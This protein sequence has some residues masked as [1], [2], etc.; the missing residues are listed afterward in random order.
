VEHARD[1]AQQPMALF[2]LAACVRGL[3]M[4]VTPTSLVI[5][6]GTAIVNNTDVLAALNTLGQEKL[7]AADV[8]TL[9]LGLGAVVQYTYDCDDACR[10]VTADYQF[11]APG[12]SGTVNDWCYTDTAQHGCP[13]GQGCD[14]D[15]QCYPPNYVMPMFFSSVTW[16]GN[17]ETAVPTATEWCETAGS[18]GNL[19]STLGSVAW[20]PF[21]INIGALGRSVGQVLDAYL[22]SIHGVS[23]A[24]HGSTANIQMQNVYGEQLGLWSDFAGST[25]IHLYDEHG[26]ACTSACKAYTGIFN[27]NPPFATGGLDCNGWTDATA[28]QSSWM[29]SA[30]DLATYPNGWPGGIGAGG[31]STC[32]NQWRIICVGT[33]PPPPP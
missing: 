8:Y 21:A 18:T 4:A 19:S 31:L 25:A 27:P 17:L 16:A 33:V 30:L 26:A 28:G 24:D 32:N 15:G 6:G 10:Y 7:D 1:F 5:T 13:L 29:A 23:Y 2:V 3:N 14:V 12:L 9:L 11:N 20:A 22:L